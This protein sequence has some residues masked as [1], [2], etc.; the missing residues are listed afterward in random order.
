MNNNFN[1]TRTSKERERNIKKIIDDCEKGRPEPRFDTAHDFDCYAAD[2]PEALKR[3]ERSNAT[4]KKELAAAKKAGD[5]RR[6]GLETIVES[7]E[8]NI[9]KLSGELAR[10]ERK[11]RKARR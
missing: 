9:R 2:V 5:R 11:L 7:E 4:N 10:T 3:M 8:H 6:G 1:D